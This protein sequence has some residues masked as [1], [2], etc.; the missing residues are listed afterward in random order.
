[1]GAQDVHLDFHTALELCNKS[2]DHFGLCP[3]KQGCFLGTG[4]G[5]GGGGREDE[6]LKARPRISPEKDRRDRGPP[7]EQ[8]KC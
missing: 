3:Q 4:T 2:T 7:P 5:G 6:R 8:W 1:M